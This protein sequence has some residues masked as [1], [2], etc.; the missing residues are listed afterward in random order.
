MPARTVSLND[1][2]HMLLPHLLE[3]INEWREH[4]PNSVLIA[5]AELR[6]KGISIPELTAIKLN[7]FVKENDR[8]DIELFFQ[9][10]LR[11][12][13]CT[14]YK[15][16]LKRR[17][18]GLNTNDTRGETSHVRTEIVAHRR[19]N[20]LGTARESEQK[21]GRQHGSIKNEAIHLSGN[22]N[23]EESLFG[24]WKPTFHVSNADTP[25]NTGEI[26]EPNSGGNHDRKYPTSKQVREYRGYTQSTYLRINRK[27]NSYSNF[28]T[29]Q[30]SADAIPKMVP[31]VST[32]AT[33][34]L[35]GAYFYSSTPN[36]LPSSFPYVCTLSVLLFLTL[37]SSL[38][39]FIK[40][41][42]GTVHLKE[43]IIL[44]SASA[45]PLL[46]SAAALF[47]GRLVLGYS[48]SPLF[49]PDSLWSP[50]NGMLLLPASG[51]TISIAAIFHRSLKR[52][53]LSNSLSLCLSVISVGG[54]M[55]FTGFLF[56]MLYQS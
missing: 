31:I 3:L 2:H 35:L 8:D 44:I 49:K 38:S 48:S 6:E 18:P 17:L 55:V 56:A 50:I 7:E 37:I 30:T 12:R 51:T 13:S 14:S 47:L 4:D 29:G 45:I 19:E 36:I 15:D 11:H 32:L 34:F 16:Y 20:L 10:F 33:Y 25:Q 27:K 24:D 41:F 26:Q 53:G 52:H 5:Y 40:S 9:E 39:L 46:F 54:A 22:A 1:L 23:K 21:S 43:E 28:S 42:S